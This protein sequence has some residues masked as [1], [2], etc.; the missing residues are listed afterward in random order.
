MLRK[1]AKSTS[2]ERFEHRGE[3]VPFLYAWFVSNREFEMRLS[4]PKGR[5][6]R[7]KIELLSFLPI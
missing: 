1:G 3:R 6:R 5:K 2:V 4:P 7:V